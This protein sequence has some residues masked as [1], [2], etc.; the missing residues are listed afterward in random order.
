M[1]N[2]INKISIRTFVSLILFTC[3]LQAGAQKAE[4]GIRYMPTISSM[5]IKT[6]E[7]G[8]VSG[9]AT[10][11]Y[12]IG[13]FLGFNFSEHVGMQVEVI[14]SSITQNFNE[15]NRQQTIELKYINI[16]LLL[17]LNTGKSNPV[18]LN[19]VAG[20]QIGLNVGSSIETTNEQ[21]T[22]N[23]VAVLSVNKGDLGFAYGAGLDF[24]LNTSKMLRLGIGFRG[25]YGLVDI[26]NNSE[27]TTTESYYVLDKTHLETYS[28]Y[29]GLSFLF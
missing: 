1:K 8:T 20:P 6:M 11:G 7:G 2:L 9:E 29:I 24:G 21:G 28:G 14:Y 17:S 26:S 3:T 4:L 27:S 5:K 22:D 13:G 15:Q 18:N 23:A 10:L 19:V 16:P 12:G 25:V